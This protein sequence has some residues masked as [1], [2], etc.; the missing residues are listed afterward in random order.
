MGSVVEVL[1]PVLVAAIDIFNVVDEL[2]A[3]QMRSKAPE[4]VEILEATLLSVA[5]PFNE[6]VGGSHAQKGIA[7]V[8]PGV[9]QVIRRQGGGAAAA[10]VPRAVDGRAILEVL[11]RPLEQSLQQTIEATASRLGPASRIPARET[12]RPPPRGRSVELVEAEPPGPPAPPH[13]VSAP[14]PA[15]PPM[16]TLMCLICFGENQDMSDP[17][18]K[19][20]HC[21]R[22][23]HASCL[24]RTWQSK[25]R[26]LA[27]TD[28]IPCPLEDHIQCSR[29][30]TEADLE[31]IV[32]RRDREEMER[33][34][35]ETERM[36]QSLI[37]GVDFPAGDFEAADFAADVPVHEEGT[38]D[39]SRMPTETMDCCICFGLNDIGDD[40]TTK[41]LHCGKNV[42]AQCL[43]SYWS[44]QVRVGRT[45][46][47]PCPLW[48][49]TGCA[50]HITEEDLRDVVTQAERDAAM[51][52]AERLQEDMMAIIREVTAPAPEPTFQCEICLAEHDV[53][54]SCTLPCNHRF[55]FEGLG[56]TFTVHVKERRLTNLVCPVPACRAA[57]NKPEHME[58]FK[59]C[60]EQLNKS[61]VYEKL[62]EFMT[63][64]DAHVVD[65][66]V[67]G[68][69]EFC[70][71][72]EADDRTDLRCRQGHQFCA[73]CEH[74]PH[75]GQTCDQKREQLERERKGQEERRH[76]AQAWE[77]ALAAG[78]KPCPMRCR[79]TG[80]FKSA[81]ECEH[82]T[83][84]CGHEF[85][86]S[87]GADRRVIYAHDQRWHKPSCI[88]YT[89][90]EDIQEAPTRQSS[91]PACAAL[92]AG[93]VCPFP[94]DDNYPQ[95]F[96]PGGAARAPAA[97][98]PVPEGAS[99]T[100]EPVVPRPGQPAASSTP[101]PAP[102]GRRAQARRAQPKA[103]GAASF[104][105]SP[106]ARQS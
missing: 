57:L 15:L 47:I 34:I 40:W 27:R 48:Q 82:V 64:E 61:D 62:L 66:R 42:H 77:A 78:W 98:P 24:K 59:A 105:F 19:T 16:G 11:R 20:L 90:R 28:N 63:R 73:D 87:C 103:A 100:P 46:N 33:S 68:C 51:A 44:A 21:N 9:A 95:S 35:R 52:S 7:G 38:V 99:A 106:A 13:A 58:I 89:R 92:P 25:C 54:G 6:A 17:R 65:C 50:R 8:L 49:H 30:I 70:F 79:F 60:F 36:N 94:A 43:K 104:E 4:D 18:V 12:P 1:S 102:G 45:E 5:E 3:E 53:E 80:G 37:L 81:N 67:P 74:G 101:A 55:C 76:D 96:M 97:P 69:K 2:L 39:P 32:S 41:V 83:C 14:V 88:R 93:Q 71:V 29:T 91:C 85:C 75:L 86:W 31:G 56:H 23:V 26:A 22:K 84:E 10:G 72:E